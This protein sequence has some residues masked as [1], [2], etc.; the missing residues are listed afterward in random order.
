MAATASE[1][2]ALRLRV[3]RQ[4][5]ANC[6]D[7]FQRLSRTLLHGP[8]FQWLLVDAPHEGLRKEVMAA[9]AQVLSA[10]GMTTNSLPLSARIKDVAEL[11]AR[12]IKNA[13]QADVVHVI[14]RP[15]WFDAG[16]WDAFNV[17][18]ERIAREARARLVFW[19]DAPAIELASRGAPDLWAWRGGVYAFSAKS[20]NLFSPESLVS[21]EIEPPNLTAFSRNGDLRT[22]PQKILRIEAI[23]KWLEVNPNVPDDLRAG[24]LAELGLSLYEIEDYEAA[25]MHWRDVELPLLR[26]MDK[27]WPVAIT[28]GQIA[29]VLE[30]RG[31]LEEAL[32]VRREEVLPIF[33]RLRDLTMQART[34]GQIADIL[35]AKGLWHEASQIREHDVLPILEKLGLTRD[36]ALVKWAIAQAPEVA[37]QS[38]RT[39]RAQS[40]AL[41]SISQ[42][43]DHL[44]R[45][46]EQVTSVIRL[47]TRQG[48]ID[49]ALRLTRDDLM[50]LVRKLGDA[51]EEAKAQITLARLLMHRQPQDPKRAAALLSMAHESMRALSLSE[52]DAVVL[53]FKQLGLPPPRP[54]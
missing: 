15:G 43:S 48:E 17:R 16:K 40:D 42:S 50:P 8:Q 14:G 31:D 5:P 20:A 38:G 54:T 11:E 28:L 23:R 22:R 41:R 33:E 53:E 9:L 49:Q 27:E 36:I 37:G 51:R 1:V 34:Q 35:Q 19:L 26:R 7:D 18:R 46:I 30:I 24:A 2:E 10:A 29:D 12:L 39:S 6:F 52:A 4:L 21:A 3:A 44:R 45:T 25:L 13:N 47:C 32:R